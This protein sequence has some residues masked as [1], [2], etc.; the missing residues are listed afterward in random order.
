MGFFKNKS[1]LARVGIGGVLFAAVGG[2]FQ[3]FNIKKTSFPNSYV[4]PFPPPKPTLHIN[5]IYRFKLSLP[6]NRKIYIRDY[7]RPMLGQFIEAGFKKF[8]F[9]ALEGNRGF[10]IITAPEAFY[11]NPKSSLCYQ[12][13]PGDKGFVL[14]TNPGNIDANDD[15]YRLS[16]LLRIGPV[17][18]NYRKYAFIF[19]SEKITGWGSNYKILK[20]KLE[21]GLRIGTDLN[22]MTDN[23]KRAFFSTEV[24]GKLHM[25]TLLY[26][27]FKRDID[28]NTPALLIP[29]KTTPLD[30]IQKHLFASRLWNK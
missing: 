9:A 23:E 25:T 19:S 5:K 16:R 13:L 10:A 12:R 29:Y 17:K 1:L 21:Q 14:S 8:H 11:G 24:K 2:L 28:E 22:S 26:L 7:V 20:R 3:V 15:S 30:D 4:F 18:G 27:Y 6:K